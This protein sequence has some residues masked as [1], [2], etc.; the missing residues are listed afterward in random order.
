MFE[1]QTPFQK[2]C[3]ENGDVLVTVADAEAAGW[4]ALFERYYPEGTLVKE[5]LFFMMVPKTTPDEGEWGLC[6]Y[7]VLH[8]KLEQLGLWPV[9]TRPSSPRRSG[10]FS[11][12]IRLVVCYDAC[13]LI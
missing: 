9:V 12:G 6:L 1:P 8:H 4:K 2:A 10:Q 13:K 7:E 5:L 11:L 3:A